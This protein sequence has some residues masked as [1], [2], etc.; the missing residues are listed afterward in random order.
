[1]TQ[2]FL[3]LSGKLI[4]LEPGLVM[5]IL[6]ATPDSFYADSRIVNSSAINQRVALMIDKGMQI[7]DI[8]G[9]ST[10][11]GSKEVS[12]EDEWGRLV[13]ILQAIRK[14]FPDLP[15][16]LDTYRSAI[17]DKAIKDYAVSMI[18]DVTAGTGDLQMAEVVAKHQVPIVLMHMQG[19]PEHMQTR[20]NYS[21]VV[22][23]LLRFF[24]ERTEHFKMYGVND[25]ILDPGFG[26]GKT[27]DHN[28]EIL[29][30]LDKIKD[31]GFPVLIGVSRKSMI[32]N[33]LNTDAASSLNG[34]SVIH[35]LARM[36]GAD[37]LRVHDVA[38]AKE[39]LELTNRALKAGKVQ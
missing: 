9:V 13:G 22:L 12:E 11:P 5:G 6:N 10:R 31:L 3:Q 15:I 19:S 7:L 25:L 23:A 21:N 35:T 34:T 26:F 2:A 32:Y 27:L 1:M 24:A 37:I 38:E 39:S 20:P 16:S 18:N 14:S 17:A 30:N 36:K 33:A 28:Y 29:I 8:G 4:D